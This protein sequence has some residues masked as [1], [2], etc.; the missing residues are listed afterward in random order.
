[1]S[2]SLKDSIA[3]AHVSEGLDET[4]LSRAMNEFGA[5]GFIVLNNVF[6]QEGIQSLNLSLAEI[7]EQ[8]FLNEF[9][10]QSKGAFERTLL[11]VP[12]KG[13]FN[14]EWL[15]A[16]PVVF[17][18]LSIIYPMSYLCVAAFNGIATNAYAPESR[19]FLGHTDL[20]SCGS[21]KNFFTKIPFFEVSLLVPLDKLKK[22]SSALRFWPG[23][24]LMSYA[25]RSELDENHGVVDLEC[26]PGDCV[27]IDSRIRHKFLENNSP[28][29]LS[30][31]VI[32]YSF[33]WFRNVES[34]SRRLPFVI[35]EDEFEGLSDRV[36]F[37][38]DHARG[39]GLWVQRPNPKLPTSLLAAKPTSKVDS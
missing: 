34:P 11:S 22:G 29:M 9:D 14:S 26:G 19:T 6:P 36:K 15:Y 35:S 5:N 17:Q 32:N 21:M 20:F 23:S 37:L 25:A 28:E 39:N 33:P 12:V 4:S 10:G 7:R 30:K 3:G 16:N 24:H 18:I 2:S 1:M 8:L 38:F 13:D 27:L 31:F